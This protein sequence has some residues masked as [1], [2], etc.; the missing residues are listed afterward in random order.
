LFVIVD[1]EDVL[2]GAH[3]FSLLPA[4]TADRLQN[5]VGRGSLA[6]CA[7]GRACWLADAPTGC[8]MW[9]AVRTE[10]LGSSGLGS[11]FA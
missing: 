8:A 5:R 6:S 4:D 1:T 10:V 11:C 2:L 7:A 9:P 3:D